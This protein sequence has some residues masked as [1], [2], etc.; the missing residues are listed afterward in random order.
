[1]KISFGHLAAGKGHHCFPLISVA[2]LSVSVF[3]GFSR[4]NWIQTLS[5]VCYNRSEKCG[6]TNILPQLG[7]LCTSKNPERKFMGRKKKRRGINDAA[8]FLLLLFLFA[9]PLPSVVFN[10]I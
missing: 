2:H 4:R 9:Y 8:A 3:L 7:F 5:A 1:M 10:I 6:A